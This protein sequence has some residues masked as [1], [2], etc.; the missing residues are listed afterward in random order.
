[1]PWTARFFRGNQSGELLFEARGF[2]CLDFLGHGRAVLSG[3]LVAC[4]ALVVFR[5]LPS[6]LAASGVYDQVQAAVGAPVD[7]DEMVSA[8]ERSDIVSCHVPAYVGAPYAMHRHR[9]GTEIVFAPFVPAGGN[10][11]PDYPVE[12]T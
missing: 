11:F 6:E 8:T 3:H 5:D 4:L 9:V 10:S 12:S 1:M 7:F 2:P